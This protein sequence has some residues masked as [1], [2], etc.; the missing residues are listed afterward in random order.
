M[1]QDMVQEKDCVVGIVTIVFFRFSKV[2]QHDHS[3]RTHLQSIQEKVTMR[4]MKKV[5]SKENMNVI[6]ENRNRNV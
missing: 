4:F 1:Q 6:Y 2:C 5:K 3:I